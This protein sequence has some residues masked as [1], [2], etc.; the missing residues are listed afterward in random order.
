MQKSIS[1]KTYYEIIK[2]IIFLLIM[3]CVG[4]GALQG[5]TWIKMTMHNQQVMFQNEMESQRLRLDL[6]LN[7]VRAETSVV[8]AGSSEWKQELI[9]LKTENK[10]IVDLIKKN[11][12]AIFNSGKVSSQFNE[13]LSL[14]LKKMSDHTYKAGTGDINEQYFT[15]VFAKEED[16][17]GKVI[18][19]PVSW[20]IFYPNKPAGEQW[21]TGVYPIEYKTNII[22]TEQQDGQNNTYL[23]SWVENNKDTD[24]IGI[25]LPIM[26]TIAEFTQV[27][28]TDTEFFIWAPHVNLNVDFGLSSIEYNVGSGLSFSM[29]GYGKTKND[30][31]WRFIDAG[32]STNGNKVWGKLTPFSYNM[33]G[34][35]PLIS[36]TFI[37]PYVG[38]EFSGG[39]I[40][41]GISIS[42]PF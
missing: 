21:K 16:S 12:E 40:L 37:G 20:V 19:I 29:S 38:Y 24:S 17:D 28:N 2:V 8:K 13:N 4:F 7:Q 32:L 39:S 14:E 5:Y 25:K 26:V 23:E 11:N 6:E 30:L 1:V 33:G 3:S 22:Q 34:M 31:S 15:K 27:K 9:K 42:I 41:G 36:N 10:V 35:L 18:E